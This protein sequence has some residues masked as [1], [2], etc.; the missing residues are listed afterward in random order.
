MPCKGGRV[1]PRNIKLHAK[2]IKVLKNA[3][4]ITT[5]QFG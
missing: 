4:I 5:A 3:L 2:E 1:A